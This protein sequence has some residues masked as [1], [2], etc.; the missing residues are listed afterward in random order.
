MIGEHLGPYVIEQELGSGGMGT[1][2]AATLERE[3][4]DVERD[5]AAP[6]EDSSSASSPERSS[7]TTPSTRP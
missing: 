6:T 5:V 1:V 7:R 3:A 2:Y 4:G